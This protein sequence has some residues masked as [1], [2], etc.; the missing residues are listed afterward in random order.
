MTSTVALVGCPTYEQPAVDAAVLRAFDLLGGAA[1]F[2]PLGGKVLLKVNL[3]APASPE[4]AVTTHPAVV[5]AAI[6]VVKAAGGV[7]LVGD[8]CA[9]EG[10]PSRRRFLDAARRAGFVEACEAEGAELVQLSAETV[11]VHNP[12]GRIFRRFPLAKAVL[13]ADAILNLPKLKTH[14]LT[15]ITGGVK[16]LFGCLPGLHKGQMHFRAQNP[17]AFAQMLVDLLVAV[18]PT[19]TLMD[20]VVAME[21]NGPRNGLPRPVGALL[22]GADAVAVDAVA[23][24]LVSVAPRSIPTLRLAAEQG[25]GTADMDRIKVLGDSVDALAVAGFVLPAPP[26]PFLGGIPGRLLKERLVAKP[27]FLPGKCKTC[28]ACVEACPVGALARGAKIPSLERSKCIA[29]YCCQE[30]CPHDAVELRRP[31]LSRLLTG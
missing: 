17:E 30:M 22:A 12:E 25:R 11:E 5:R 24:S 1:R 20:A 7:P 26:S 31:L 9:F 4:A 13:E 6:R 10:P 27:S 8:C 3:L 19:L 21:G 2:F 28:W 16:N 18:R 14:A 15:R 23:C 29:C